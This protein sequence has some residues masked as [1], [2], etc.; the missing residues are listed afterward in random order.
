M[1]TES[2]SV[3]ATVKAVTARVT[4]EISSSAKAQFRGY[5][6]GSLL[7]TARHNVHLCEEREREVI[8][9][10]STDIAYQAYALTSVL[11]SVAFLEAL[12]NEFYDDAHDAEADTGSKYVS[13]KVAEVAAP[14]RKALSSFHDALGNRQ[15]PALGR[16]QMSLILSGVEQLTAGGEPYQSAALLTQWRNAL[17]HFK[18]VWQ[19]AGEEK[20]L[21]K[22]LSE[23]VKANALLPTG[24]HG[25]WI[26]NA[27]LGAFGAQWAFNTAL[28]FAKAWSDRLGLP[29]WYEDEMNSLDEQYQPPINREP[30][31]GHSHS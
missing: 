21:A 31:D 9:V 8:G 1:S 15:Y 5:L 20:D 24:S 22:K 2:E 3:D 25:D 17:I 26:T 4:I 30:G 7:W 12:I 16:Y 27:G 18:P 10:R 11:T 23:R 14:V 29:Y 13:P 28:T 19:T 6:A